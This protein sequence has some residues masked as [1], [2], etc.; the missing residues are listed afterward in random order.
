VVDHFAAGRH[1]H[2]VA[3]LRKGFPFSTYV[4]ELLLLWATTEAEEWV[5]SMIYLP[6]S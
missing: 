4:D 1:T 2:G 3:L 5:D 6:L